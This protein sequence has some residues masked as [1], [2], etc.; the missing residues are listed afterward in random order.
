MVLWGPSKLEWGD[1]YGHHGAARGSFGTGRMF[2]VY[3][4]HR[5]EHNSHGLWSG[6]CVRTR[7]ATTTSGGGRG[8]ALYVVWGCVTPPPT[9]HKSPSWNPTLGA[10]P[11]SPPKGPLANN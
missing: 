6:L 2:Q 3:L 8:G 5:S 7:K 4:V 1:D 10:S 9:P 11:P